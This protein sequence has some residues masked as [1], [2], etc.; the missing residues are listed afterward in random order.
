MRHSL[1]AMIGLM[2]VLYAFGWEIFHA[3]FS[4]TVSFILMHTVPRKQVHVI[5]TVLAFLKGI[6]IWFNISL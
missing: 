3:L 1:C 4:S 2:M 5:V 6:S